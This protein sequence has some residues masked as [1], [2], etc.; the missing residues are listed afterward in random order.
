MKSEIEKL[1]KGLA[2]GESVLPYFVR[3]LME[4]KKYKNPDYIYQWVDEMSVDEIGST[5]DKKDYDPHRVALN[6]TEYYEGIIQRQSEQQ[7]RKQEQLQRERMK[8]R[9]FFSFNR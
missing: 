2:K 1:K 9:T 7:T 5:L 8:R 4:S 6:K 3:E